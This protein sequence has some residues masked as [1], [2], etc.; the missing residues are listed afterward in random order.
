M[1][2]VRRTIMLGAAFLL[3]ASAVS[4]QDSVMQKAMAKDIAE[5]AEKYVALAEAMPQDDYAW[6]PEDG[7]RSVGE[8]FTHMIGANYGLPGVLGVEAPASGLSR[9]D[10]AAMTDKDEI[11]K[12]LEASFAHLIESVMSVEDDQLG[13]A[14]SF[15]GQEGTY[16]SFLILLTTH[17]HEHLGQSIAY[18]R[19]NHVKPPWSM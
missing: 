2:V 7:V 8:V 11:V 1:S 13:E 9:D 10:L 12:H 3:G 18:A 19:T 15:F 14:L 5:V 17:S 16:G 6:R 4:A